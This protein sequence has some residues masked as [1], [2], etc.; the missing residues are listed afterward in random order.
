MATQILK[1]LNLSL[2]VQVEFYYNW[3]QWIKTVD[4]PTQASAISEQ[5]INYSQQLNG[6]VINYTAPTVEVQKS[7]FLNLKD[8]LSS[9]P[10]G[11]G[12]LSH[13]EQHHT[14]NEKARKLLVDAFLHHCASTGISVSKAAC[15][16]LSM[17]IQRTF[18]GEIAVGI[19][20]YMSRLS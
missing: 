14:L 4:Q 8:I 3:S 10:Y 9:G 1:N 18:D 2:G 15:K 13:Y 19:E 6:G 17:Q 16:S 5:S 12:V 20:R 7:D 11:P